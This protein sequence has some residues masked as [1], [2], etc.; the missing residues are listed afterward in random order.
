MVIGSEHLMPARIVA[1]LVR[2][3]PG[4]VPAWRPRS[5]L[6]GSSLEDGRYG[7]HREAESAW[8]EHLL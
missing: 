2:V 6:I 8:L 1:P 4:H 5:G 3:R 7:Q